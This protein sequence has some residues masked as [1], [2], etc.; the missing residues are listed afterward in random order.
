MG[1]YDSELGRGDNPDGYTESVGATSKEEA[2]AVSDAWINREDEKM[3]AI[4]VYGI[5]GKK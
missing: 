5:E 3:H 4:L 1:L 2:M